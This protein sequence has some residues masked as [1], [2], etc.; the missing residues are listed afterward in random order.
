VAR[1]P[2]RNGKD[3]AEI[4]L[5]WPPPTLLPILLRRVTFAALHRSSP[6]DSANFRTIQNSKSISVAAFLK[7]AV[8]PSRRLIMNESVELLQRHFDLTPSEARLT[9]RLLKGDRL[10]SAAAKLDISYETARGHLKNIFNKTGARRQAELV[11]LIIAALPGC[12]EG[13]RTPAIS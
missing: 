13:S 12:L 6:Y 11:V 7:L 1:Q 8:K 2:I 5:D 9:L 10:Q 4:E 3:E